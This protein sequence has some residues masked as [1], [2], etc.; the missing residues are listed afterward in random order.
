MTSDNASR[1][2][3]GTFENVRRRR[4]LAGSAGAGTLML[5]GCLG[6]DGTD[7]DTGDDTGDTTDDDG[8]GDNGDPDGERVTMIT[9]PSGTIGEQLGNGLMS[10]LSQNSGYTGN[11]QAGTGSIAA[12]AQVMR[13]EAELTMAVTTMTVDGYNRNEPFDDDF[14]YDPLQMTSLYDLRLAVVCKVDDDYQYVSD[15]D[16]EPW[17]TGPEAASF[18]PTLER[19]YSLI[20]DDFNAVHQAPNDMGSQ[21][22]ADQVKAAMHMN[23]FGGSIPS[24]AQEIAARNDLRLL[25]WQDDEM[26]LI[27][28]DPD[29]NSVTTANQFYEEENQIDEFVMEDETFML[30]T[31][32]HLL[33]HSGVS[34]SVVYD[35]MNTWFQGRD[36][37]P[38]VHAA[39]GAWTN[40]D[41]WPS[42]VDTR[43]PFHP[44]AAEVLRE[45][46]LWHDDFEEGSLD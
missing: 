6:D 19:G 12:I 25:G 15:L 45:N 14:E 3:R 32:Y 36:E 9:N 29:V 40:E 8:D 7:D 20:M 18:L 2:G 41:F 4:F 38:D 21:L 1:D 34:E 22:A 23:I 27:E 44:G 33:A 30:V 24:F 42:L 10:Y 11:A 43:L 13:G 26:A 5:A 46:D 28:D 35:A 39:F 37:L 16:G 17:A 31:N